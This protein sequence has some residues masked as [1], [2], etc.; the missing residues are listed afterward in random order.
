MRSIVIQYIILS[1]IGTFL[2]LLSSCNHQPPIVNKPKSIIDFKST[3]GKLTDFEKGLAIKIVE[4]SEGDVRR[5]LSDLPNEIS[6]EIEIVD[7]DL[8]VV[9]GVTGRAETN[10]PALVLIQISKKFPGGVVAAIHAGLRPTLFHE[11]HHLALGWAIQDNK[12]TPT[13]QTATIVEGLAEVFSEIHTGVKFKENHIPDSVNADEWVAEIMA[14][15][16]DADYQKWM[17]QHPDGRTSIGYRTGNYL[18]KKAMASSNKSIIELSELS[19][20]EVYELTGY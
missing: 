4:E 20:N 18:I 17:F 7:W 16:K 12:F 19:I 2:M 15:P 11:L 6:Y 13:I 1:L 8:D 9:G 3:G 10:N 14:L 5:L